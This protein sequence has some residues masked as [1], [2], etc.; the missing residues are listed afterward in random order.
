[1]RTLASL[2]ILLFVVTGIVH[3]DD[4]A[5]DPAID[6]TIASV[7]ADP[8]ARR[9]L[10]D[11]CVAVVTSP[12]AEWPALH[13]A[14]RL[15]AGIGSEASI[16]PLAE[17]LRDPESAHLARYAL[18][19]MPYPAV[20]A[21]LR[22]ALGALTGAARVGVMGSIAVRRDAAAV[23]ALITLLDDDDSATVEGSITAL[24]RIGGPEAVAVLTS[25]LPEVPAALKSTLTNALFYAAA[26][27]EP[28]QAIPV[29][30]QLLHAEHP[31]YVRSGAFTGLLAAAPE[32]AV[33]RILE[34]IAG[35][36][37]PVRV[38]AVA[39]AAS[40][41]G[42]NATERFAQTLPALDDALQALMIEALAE[43][44]DP[45]GLSVM[46][47]ALG[48]SNEAVRLAALKAIADHGDIGS[49]EP[50]YGLIARSDTRRERLAAIE[51]LRRLRGPDVDAALLE[52]LNTAPTAIRPELMEALVQ[53][54]TVAAI[55]AFIAQTATEEVRGAAFRALGHMAGPDH[56]P[57]LLELLMQLEG[58]TGRAEAETALFALCGRIARERSDISIEEAVYGDLPDGPSRDVTRRVSRLVGDGARRIE[59][60]NRNFGDPAPNVV[61]TLHVDF[62]VN[63]IPYSR[64]VAE[65]DTLHFPD[66]IVPQEVLDMLSAHLEQAPSPPAKVSLLR[67]LGRLGDPRTYETLA[68]HINAEDDIVRDGAIRTLAN[69]PEPRAAAALA[70]I[71]ASAN[72]TAHRMVALRGSVRLLRTGE[73][74]DAKT[75]ALYNALIASANTADEH[76][77][78]IAG[79]ADLEHAEALAAVAPFLED[80]AVREE[81]AIAAQRIRDALGDAAPAAI[82]MPEPT[83]AGFERIFNGKTLDGWAGDPAFWR[84]EDGHIIGE[85]TEDTPAKVNTFLIWEGGT[86]DDFELCFRFRMDSEWANSGIQI[87]SERFEDY[88]VRG[89]QPDIATDDWITGICFEEGG[90]GILAR[91]GQRLVITPD[92]EKETVRFAEEEALN[93]HIRYDDWNSYRIIAQGNKFVS[94]ING[95]VMHEVIDDSPDARH[96]GIIAFQLHTGPPMKIRFKDIEIKRLP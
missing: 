64:S 41:P 72:D 33:D 63:G 77:M 18:E 49:L 34:A 12:D 56:L 45:V 78:I 20:D 30:E 29:Y 38:V 42:D 15:L 69:W 91:R 37:V 21:V 85:T 86:L 28:E 52:A 61:K 60:N 32:Q 51:T 6:A 84:V 75:M 43:R 71:F 44:G 67:V 14:I 87:R 22:E 24:G 82:E 48:S 80:D 9:A 47:D 16:E 96:S 54:D 58:D 31:D 57:T 11:A 74:D 23:P 55:D 81:A 79:L 26:S 90:R 5:W 39:A 19:A 76:K 35:D 10:E 50:V 36:D 40:A 66:D 94:A 92:G 73:L 2:C 8:E 53:R 93:R 17:R 88:R 68:A 59:V 4:N 46:Y 3:A 7:H 70:D 27:L 95:H 89:Y 25:R 62:V 65:N 13:R 83:I 1:M